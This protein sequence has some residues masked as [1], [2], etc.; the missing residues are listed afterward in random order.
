MCPCTKFHLIWRNSDFEM[1]FAQK[2]LNDKNFGKKT[3]KFEM[4]IY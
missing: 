3:V 4:R 2:N 1:K